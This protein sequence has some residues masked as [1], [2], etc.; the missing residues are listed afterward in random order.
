V[1]EG[2]LAHIRKHRDELLAIHHYFWKF[3]ARVPP[4]RHNIHYLILR[5]ALRRSYSLT[6]A[7]FELVE[8][9]NFVSAAP[10]VRLELDNGLRVNLV[11]L[12]GDGHKVL[13]HLAAGKRLDKLKDAD[14]NRL[15]DRFVVNAL[16]GLFPWLP[17]L[18]SEGSRFVHFSN[19]HIFAFDESQRD[20]AD[21]DTFFSEVAYIELV[22]SFALAAKFSYDFVARY[23]TK[24][25]GEW[26]AI[27]PKLQRRTQPP[28]ARG[29]LNAKALRDLSPR[30]RQRQD[31]ARRELIA[32]P[33]ALDASLARI[34]F[35]HGLLTCKLQSGWNVVDGRFP[36]IRTRLL[37]QRAVG[38][39]VALQLDVEV[40]LPDATLRES[41]MGIG[42]NRA[43]AAQDAMRNFG[44]G[45]LHVVLAGLWDRTDHSQVDVKKW[46]IG[47]STWRVYQGHFTI[48]CHDVASIQLP[49]ELDSQLEALL[50]SRELPGTLHWFRM[51][52][53]VVNRTRITLEAL[54]DNE[55]WDEAEAAIGRLPW[56]V[57]QDYFSVRAFYILRRDHEH[58]ELWSGFR[59]TDDADTADDIA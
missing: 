7:F 3:L 9:E 11:A 43:A 37:N 33:D 42:D 12:C 23:R 15:T 19:V 35:A 40:L 56:N 1:D 28:H 17:R 8:A 32:Q 16:T 48:K 18:Y 13:V 55:R 58:G 50:C 25:L 2:L 49:S 52:F 6:R 34:L 47:K 53:G 59:T 20:L 4:L 31:K 41:F 57:T 21:R 5:G 30:V 51:F 36:A 44:I 27:L 26:R 54:L 10:L 29:H 46:S 22:E 24:C 39:R 14:G 38:H 45:S